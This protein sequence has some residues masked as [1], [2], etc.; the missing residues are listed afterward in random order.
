M[1][2]KKYPM[3]LILSFLM[4]NAQAM[5]L[6]I[7]EFKKYDNESYLRVAQYLKSTKD[8]DIIAKKEQFFKDR[9]NPHASRVKAYGDA[10]KFINSISDNDIPFS[11]VG[12]LKIKELGHDFREAMTFIVERNNIV[13][14]AFNLDILVAMLQ[15]SLPESYQ[16]HSGFFK[17]E[18]HE[19]VHEPKTDFQGL[20]RF[21]QNG[22]QL[23]KVD[24][25]VS[26]DDMIEVIKKKSVIEAL[27]M[28]RCVTQQGIVA[29]NARFDTRV[30]N[31]CTKGNVYLPE[32]N[33][34][35]TFKDL[36]NMSQECEEIS[37]SIIQKSNEGV[38]RRNIAK[39]FKFTDE[40]VNMFKTRKKD[41]TFL[42]NDLFQNAQITTDIPASTTFEK[43]MDKILFGV[44]LL[45]VM[46]APDL[47][48]SQTTGLLQGMA[49]G[50]A[51]GVGCFMLGQLG[52]PMCDSQNSGRKKMLEWFG[53][54]DCKPI[55]KGWIFVGLGSMHY[56]CTAIAQKFLGWDSTAWHVVGGT[57]H[58]F[59]ALASMFLI[60]NMEDYGNPFRRSNNK[61]VPLT[62]GNLL[63]GPKFNK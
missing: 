19:G 22:R 36:E 4:H 39:R 28:F 20:L 43:I 9:G 21:Q 56:L 16:D 44:P 31:E 1:V 26:R 40:H 5:E 24:K 58:A 27:S 47:V 17:S 50:A 30:D 23:K 53:A 13:G 60:S 49:G 29:L 32:K 6:A 51:T 41:L 8:N 61:G 14:L 34:Y 48:H 45:V 18:Y 15:N 55:K 33:Y 46:M 38:G 52:V 35:F 3:G 11:E 37:K 42:Q 7:P 2:A 10:A 54:D 63:N 25:G 62:F 12:F 57:I 59:R